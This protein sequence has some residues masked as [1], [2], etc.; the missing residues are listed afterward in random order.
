MILQN[1]LITY[2][3]IYFFAIGSAIRI[4]TASKGELYLPTVA[5]LLAAFCLLLV[6]E[7]WISHRSALYAHSYL[8]VQTSIVF[9]LAILPPNNDFFASLFFSLTLHSMHH[10][11]PRIGF[12][13]V[14][15]FTVV[16]IVFVI[17]IYGWGLG[18][19][20]AMIYAAAYLFIGSYAAFLSQAEAD[21]EENQKLLDELQTTHQQLQSYS[22]QAKELAVV[23]ERNRLARNLHD[24]V[25]QTIFSINLTAEAACI[26]FDQNPVEVIPQLDKLQALAKSTLGEMRSLIFELQPT[27]VAEQGLIRA[28]R[29]HITM[30]RKQHGLIVDLKIVGKPHLSPDQAQRLFRVIQEALN[31]VVKHA[32]TN[33]ASVTIRSKNDRIFLIIEDRGRGFSME[34][35]PKKGKQMGLSTMRERVEMV[36][37]ALTIDSRPGEGTR[38]IVEVS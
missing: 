22:D 31:N 38:V 26:L 21:R 14:G 6:I 1:T 20:L 4:L 34:S 17:Q 8:A 36:G 32:G 5:S 37:G 10:F 29:H 19:P 13:W 30:L 28:L 7:P 16:M 12:R 33:E 15:I 24:S 35:I 11:H 27:T 9:T 25:T 3:G 18:V 23:A 2:L